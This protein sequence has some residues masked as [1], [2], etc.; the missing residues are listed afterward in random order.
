MCDHLWSEWNLFKLRKETL[1]T[2]LVSHGTWEAV[3]LRND[4]ME[5]V[6]VCE[7]CGQVERKEV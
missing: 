6:R 7:R 3:V 2:P 5:V 1:Q 4:V